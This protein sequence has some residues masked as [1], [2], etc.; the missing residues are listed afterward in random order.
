MEPSRNKRRLEIMLDNCV[1]CGRYV[2]EG[3]MVC[4]LCAVGVIPGVDKK[5]AIHIFLR[6]Y[7]KGKENAIHSKELQKVF[8]MDGRA[9]RRKISS[10]RKDGVP[11]CSDE[12]GYYYA[13]NQQ[14]I[15]KTVCRL[16]G[17]VTG[18]SNARTG[19]LF[20]SLFPAAINVDVSICVGDGERL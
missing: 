10:L 3:R 13:D 8:D 6:E 19:L 18:V 15:N 7:H 1:C 5:S 16:N 12:D 14:E 17:M 9:I 4:P 2:P 11:I 20:A